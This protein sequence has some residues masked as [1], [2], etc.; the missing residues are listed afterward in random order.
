M[1]KLQIKVDIEKIHIGLSI[2]LADP[3]GIR[4]VGLRD[5]KSPRFM[6]NMNR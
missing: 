2:R 3:I 5:N 6:T 1:D 4:Q